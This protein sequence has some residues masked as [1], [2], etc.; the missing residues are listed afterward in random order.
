M[1][2]KTSIPQS[3]Y[4]ICLNLYMSVYLNFAASSVV[5]YEKPLFAKLDCSCIYDLPLLIR[6]FAGCW[7]GG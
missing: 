6:V 4:H 5:R 2:V 3:V 1:C 7:L